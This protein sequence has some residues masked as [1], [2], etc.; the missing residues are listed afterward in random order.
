MNNMMK[1]S[2]PLTGVLLVDTLS[3]AGNV[4]IISSLTGISYFGP[5][6][7]TEDCK[8]RVKAPLKAFHKLAGTEKYESPL[9]GFHFLAP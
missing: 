9:T 5:L 4:V 1:A 8:G 7:G 2:W 3:L 6:T